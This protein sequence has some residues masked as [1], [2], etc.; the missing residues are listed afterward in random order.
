MLH[1]APDRRL[2][3]IT[4]SQRGTS[5]NNS[6]EAT[7]FLVTAGITDY[8]Q[9][10]A[11]N[12]LVDSLK[13]AGLWTKMKVIYPFVGGTALAH[14]TNLKDPTTNILTFSNISHSSSGIFATNIASVGSA[15]SAYSSVSDSVTDTSFGYYGTTLFTVSNGVILGDGATNSTANCIAVAN[16]GSYNVYY[17]A[18]GGSAGSAASVYSTG[19]L[20]ADGFKMVSI[21]GTT[22]RVSTNQIE[23]TPFTSSTIKSNASWRIITNGAGNTSNTYSFFFVGNGLTS[24]E[25]LTLHN[26]VGTYQNILGRR[27]Y[28]FDSNLHPWTNRFVSITGLTS[29]TQITA[30]NQLI[31]S[32]NNNGWLDTNI[33]YVY[34]FLGTDLTKY[35]Y[36]LDGSAGSIGSNTYSTLGLDPNNIQNAGI[37]TAIFTSVLASSGGCIGFYCNEDTNINGY[38]TVS[39]ASTSASHIGIIIRNPSNQIQVLMYGGGTLTTVGTNTNAIGC[40]HLQIPAGYGSSISSTLYKNGVAYGTTV[41]HGTTAASITAQRVPGSFTNAAGGSRR[42]AISY[43]GTGSFTAGQIATLNTIIQTFVTAL[44]RQ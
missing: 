24:A 6:S 12:Y 41:T 26:I 9:T 22:A 40:Y 21:L 34:P 17:K 31:N 35:A 43:I 37:N 39:A 27:I 19:F 14:Q 10:T 16:A 33:L 36:A 5:G 1:S 32:L 42:F 20:G 38:D 3:T 8:T 25:M 18:M 11:I 2:P 30:L 28:A 4:I 29:N 23:N 13:D 15:T 7:A 44:G